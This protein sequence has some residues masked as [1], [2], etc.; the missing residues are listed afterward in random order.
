M[1][2]RWH[3]LIKRDQPTIRARPVDHPDSPRFWLGSVSYMGN[4]WAVAG[5][6]GSELEALRAA[7]R[8]RESVVKA[9][10]PA[11]LA[12]VE[13]RANAP[14]APNHGAKMGGSW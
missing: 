8:Y 2:K 13:R 9:S 12:D 7:A 10:T 5:Q 3:P 1:P 6:Y 11:V 4:E 14:S